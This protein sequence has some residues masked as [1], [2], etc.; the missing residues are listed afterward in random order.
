MTLFLVASEIR[1]GFFKVYAKKGQQQNLRQLQLLTYVGRPNET[2]SKL[3]RMLRSVR[4][5]AA[6]G[7][8]QAS[9]IAS[10]ILL[11]CIQ[12]CLTEFQSGWTTVNISLPFRSFRSMR[13]CVHKNAFIPALSS[14]W[15]KCDEAAVQYPVVH[16]DSF[17]LSRWPDRRMSSLALCVHVECSLFNV[18]CATAGKARAACKNLLQLSQGLSFGK[19]GG[20]K[21]R[22]NRTAGFTNVGPSLSCSFTFSRL[23]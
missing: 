12:L 10:C 23:E 5:V 16:A 2:E 7:R 11:Y 17:V 3:S 20:V 15:R 4:Q 14:Y 22:S 6:P 8:S 21:S 18:C 9:P 13:L 19:T 1:G